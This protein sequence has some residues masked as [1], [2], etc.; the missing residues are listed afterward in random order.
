MMARSRLRSAAYRSPWAEMTSKISMIRKSFCS[1][2]TVDIS[3]AGPV[4][5]RDEDRERAS[6]G[7]GDDIAASSWSRY[8]R[9]TLGSTLFS[10][11]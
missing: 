1:R 8:I 3:A 10:T 2:S 4:V 11:S 7:G 6:R 5:D 9:R